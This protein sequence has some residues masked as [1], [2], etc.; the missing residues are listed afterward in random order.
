[1]I[2]D[3][4]L[5][6]FLFSLNFPI[7]EIRVLEDNVRY[8][9]TGHNQVVTSTFN[10]QKLPLPANSPD[11]NPI[12]NAWHILKVRLWKRFTQN[13]WKRPSSEDELWA[14]MEEEWEAID[15][16]ILDRLVDSMAGRVEAVVAVRGN[17]IKW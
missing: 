7:E 6:P 13:T 11:L 5:I 3:Q 2:Y 4:Y 17:H 12:E 8:H 1:E 10:I 16:E 15:Q 9:S 14:V